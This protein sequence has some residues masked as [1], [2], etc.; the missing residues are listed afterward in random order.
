MRDIIIEGEDGP[1][2]PKGLKIYTWPDGRF[3]ITIEPQPCAGDATSSSE[4]RDNIGG[5][6]GLVA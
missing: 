6:S 3:V 5:D 2:L 1:L 4:A